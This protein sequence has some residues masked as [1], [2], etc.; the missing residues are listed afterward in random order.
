MI[1]SHPIQSIC[2]G[3]PISCAGADSPGP[4]AGCLVRGQAAADERP[5]GLLPGEW[6]A[7]GSGAREHQ[8]VVTAV[9][10]R[11]TYSSC[12]PS[13]LTPSSTLTM[14]PAITAAP[15][16]VTLAHRRTSQRPWPRRPVLTRSPIVPG[17]HPNRVIDRPS[18]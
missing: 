3:L 9:S 8:V 10:G 14:P 12:L 17:D 1:P 18:C 15:P 4:D 16:I 6:R 13:A 5:A 7:F 11:A 2:G